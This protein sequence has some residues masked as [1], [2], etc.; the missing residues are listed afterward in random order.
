MSAAPARLRAQRSAARPR[1]MASADWHRRPA[2]SPRPWQCPRRPPAS[3]LFWA[4]HRLRW[5]QACAWCCPARRRSASPGLLGEVLPHDRAGGARDRH[6]SRTPRPVMF[7]SNHS[8][9]V[10]IPVLGGVLPACFVAKGEVAGWPLI[11]TV[12]RLGRTV[13]ISRNRGAMA[14]EA[15]MMPG[16]GGAGDNLILFPEGTTSD[17]SRV[18]PF[19]TSF[20]AAAVGPPPPLCSRSRSSMT[21]S[22]GCRRAGPAGRCSPGTATWTSPRTTGGSRSTGECGSACCCT[23]PSTRATIRTARRSPRRSGGSVA[24][25]PATLRQNRPARAVRHR[26]VR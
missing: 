20:F 23:R 12:A 24:D 15:E 1:G 16:G 11:G 14:R 25:G 9:W 5:V 2:G 17:G 26:T 13:F 10:D 18:L 22:P 4:H 3:R 21:G 7:V 6:S 19:R 8:S